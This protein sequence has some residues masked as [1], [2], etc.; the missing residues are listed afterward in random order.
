MTACAAYA[1]FARLR[2]LARCTA[3]R[4]LDLSLNHIVLGATGEPPSSGLLL[5]YGGTRHRAPRPTRRHTRVVPGLRANPRPPSGHD[6]AE[7]SGVAALGARRRDCGLH[8]ALALPA[9]Q[10]LDLS[11][12]RIE[13]F[14]GAMLDGVALPRGE[15]EP[16]AAPGSWASPSLATLNLAANHAGS[17]S[18][19]SANGF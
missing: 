18:F 17:S 4:H 10:H 5:P 6:G 13:R 9:L 16:A 3:L 2:S 19:W 15:P 1:C 8:V 7:G 12:N 11:T 14:G